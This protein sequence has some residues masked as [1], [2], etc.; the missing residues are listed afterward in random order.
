MPG[1]IGTPLRL[2]GHPY[3]RHRPRPRAV[4]IPSGGKRSRGISPLPHG[5]I[6][7]AARD[8]LFH[9]SHRAVESP[10][11]LAPNSPLTPTSRI[12]PASSP[13]NSIPP[14]SSPCKLREPHDVSSWLWEAA[15]SA[16]TAAK[17]RGQQV[18]G[19]K[20]IVPEEPLRANCTGFLHGLPAQFD[21]H[22][23]VWAR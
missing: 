4:V 23:F 19:T 21:V 22:D 8:L 6:P 12:I 14:A 13:S 15:P 20:A 5:V 11:L 18:Y 1:T 2:G 3:L 10:P 16:F 9:P 7:S 17:V